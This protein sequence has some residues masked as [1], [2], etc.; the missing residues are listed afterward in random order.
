MKVYNPDIVCL[1]EVQNKNINS[2]YYDVICFM[3]SKG[4]FKFVGD[5]MSNSE[6]LPIFWKKDKF[7][8]MNYDNWIYSIGSNLFKNRGFNC[9]ELK[10]IDK[11]NKQYGNYFLIGNT[12]WKAGKI[13][14]THREDSAS[15]MIS[16][17]QDINKITNNEI[18]ITLIAGDFNCGKNSKEYLVLKN[19]LSETSNYPCTSVGFCNNFCFKA[20]DFIFYKGIENPSYTVGIQTG[21]SDHLP[22]MLSF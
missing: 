1:Q 17:I 3:A 22:V 15:D 12:H 16:I 20:I 13:W 6:S 5:E 14:A 2:Q 11:N 4:Y 21:T 9:V 18:S 7:M 8:R 19:Q 10:C